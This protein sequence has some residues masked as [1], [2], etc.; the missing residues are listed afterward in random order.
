MARA[1]TPSAMPAQPVYLTQATWLTC[2][3]KPATMATSAHVTAA[4]STE[5]TVTSKQAR[6][7]RTTETTLEPG[8]PICI[9]LPCDEG[10][11]EYGCWGPT[12]PLIAILQ[13]HQGL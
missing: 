4:H 7:P 8:V 11:V 12:P 9:L 6:A 3:L 13:A 1:T 2:P 5:V 10:S